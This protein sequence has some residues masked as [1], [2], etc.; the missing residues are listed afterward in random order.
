[1]F[2][3]LDKDK[4]FYSSID[5]KSKK[6]QIPNINKIMKDRSWTDLSTERRAKAKTSKLLQKM[7][8]IYWK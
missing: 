2:I 6:P 7:N 4:Q 3:I 5:V 8:K 1:M